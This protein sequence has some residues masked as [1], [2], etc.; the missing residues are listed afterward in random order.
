MTRAIEQLHS[1][2]ETPEHTQQELVL[3]ASLGMALFMS[4]SGTAPQVKH[5]FDQAHALC[6]QAGDCPQIFPALFDFRA[7]LGARRA[8][9]G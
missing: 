9:T 7:A 6:G 3:Q 8:G 2:P 4:P 1:L 5:A